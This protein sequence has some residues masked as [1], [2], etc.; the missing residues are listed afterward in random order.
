MSEHPKLSSMTPHER[1]RTLEN[2]LLPPLTAEIARGIA[3][4]LAI[5]AAEREAFRKGQEVMRDAAATLAHELHEH[6]N[7][8]GDRIAALPILDAAPKAKDRA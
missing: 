1:A 6:S 4:P 7:Y 5:A 3:I 2:D 8:I